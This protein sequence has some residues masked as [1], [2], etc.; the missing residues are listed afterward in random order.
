MNNIKYSY[1]VLH[2]FSVD[3]TNV[4]SDIIFRDIVNGQVINA[5]FV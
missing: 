3:L 4:L 5:F 2:G 1:I